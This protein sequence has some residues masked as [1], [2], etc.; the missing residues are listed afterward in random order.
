[1][2]FFKSIF[3]KKTLKIFISLIILFSICLYF[4]NR[5]IKLKSNPFLFNEIDKV[6]PLKTGLVLGTSKH[7]GNGSINP[8][9]QN[10]LIA[11]KNLYFQNKIKQLIVSGDN[12]SKYYNEP[13][14][15]K[16]DLI[17]MGVPDSVIFIDYAGFR[18]FDSM[19]RLKAIFNQDSAIVISQ[20]FHNERA[21][22]IAQQKNI[23]V[24]GYCAKDVSQS[25]G[26]KTYLR[27][28]FAR[29]KVFVDL[30]FNKQPKFYGPKIKM[31]Y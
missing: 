17:K 21:I 20:Q 25:I 7:L 16:D 31:I 4:A 27:E 14:D 19:V 26:F 6:K 24:Y 11:A 12:S 18:T 22:F 28:Y 1:M 9:Y 10:R 30:L 8:F 23:F 13:Q 5:T 2:K 29:L 15:M 3:N